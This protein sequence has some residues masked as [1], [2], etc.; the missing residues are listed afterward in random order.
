MRAPILDGSN[1]LGGRLRNRRGAHMAQYAVL[2]LAVGMAL[3]ATNGYVSRHYAGAL[4]AA[5]TDM[6]GV[7]PPSS[8]GTTQHAQSEAWVRSDIRNQLV[9]KE[10]E[11]KTDWGMSTGSSAANP[12]HERVKHR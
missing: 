7:S 5:S 6:L 10:G 8:G 2:T 12:T 1:S 3:Y 11:I 9:M 4:I